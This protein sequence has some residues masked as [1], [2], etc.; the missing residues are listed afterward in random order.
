MFTQNEDNDFIFDDRPIKKAPRT[1]RGGTGDFA[2]D[3]KIAI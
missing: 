1:F 3:I 2:D